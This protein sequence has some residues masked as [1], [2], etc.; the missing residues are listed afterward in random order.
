MTV[1]E[2]SKTCFGKPYVVDVEEH[3]E[4]IKTIKEALEEVEQYRAI[5]LTPELI[6]AMQGHNIA[7][8]ND[9]GE[10]QSLGTVEE[11]KEAM[12]KQISKKPSFVDTR[13]R[14]RGERYGECV[15]LDRCYKCPS[16]NTHIF[17]DF[18]SEIYCKCCGQKID[19]SEE[20]D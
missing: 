12:K 9:L 1:Q 17:H 5:G 11:L 19:W 4:A 20:D 18:D 10:Y 16:C 8:I 2:A 6:E 14:Q 3:E 15:T 13:F 7:L